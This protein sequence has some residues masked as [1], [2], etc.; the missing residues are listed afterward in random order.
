MNLFP[1]IRGKP[2]PRRVGRF[3]Q[4]EHQGSMFVFREPRGSSPQLTSEIALRRQARDRK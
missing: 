4:I 3:I 2:Q 1:E